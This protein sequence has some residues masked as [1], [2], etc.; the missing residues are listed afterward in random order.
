MRIVV[1]D[2][3]PL[4]YLV[5][6]GHAELLPRL[7]ET[8]TIPALVQAEMLHS[9]APQAVRDWAGAPPPWLIVSSVP[10]HD[11]AAFSKLHAG[12]AA[13]IVL[14]LSIQ[15]ELILMDDRAG[16]AA[17]LTQGLAVIGTLGVLDLAARSGLVDLDEVF[18]R[19]KATNFRYPPAL[20]TAMLAAWRKDGRA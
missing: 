7:F 13:A 12:E 4:Q 8:V 5:L 6:I 1:A 2:T 18:T 14:A 15:A 17:A 16:V 11:G 19:L 9:G 20:L 3:S 10:L